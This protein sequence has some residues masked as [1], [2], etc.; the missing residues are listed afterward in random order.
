MR[1]RF[2][3]VRAI[4]LGELSG[5]SIEIPDGDVKELQGR[6]IGYRMNV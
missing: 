5:D 2:K 4:V 6:S 3:P 1:V